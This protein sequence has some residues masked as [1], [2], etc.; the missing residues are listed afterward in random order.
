MPYI[1]QATAWQK[2]KYIM[3]AFDIDTFIKLFSHKK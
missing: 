2:S 3:P 1:V